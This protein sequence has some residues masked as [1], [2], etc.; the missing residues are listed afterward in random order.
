MAGDPALVGLLVGL[1]FRAFSM[2]PAA[3]PAVKRGLL[4][5]DSQVAGRIAREALRAPTA[6]AVRAIIAPLADGMH[7]IDA[8]A[9]SGV[10]Q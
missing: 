4:R 2:A 9:G 1:G 6:E 5:L 10:R 8:G 3:I 7:P